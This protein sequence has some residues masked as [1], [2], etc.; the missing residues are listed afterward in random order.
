MNPHD[1]PSLVAAIHVWVEENAEKESALLSPD[2]VWSV[3]AK[4]LLDFIY[5]T[6]GLTAP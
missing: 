1:V 3:N 2:A 4:E 5:S 6:T